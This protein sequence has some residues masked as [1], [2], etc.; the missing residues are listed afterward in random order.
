[1]HHWEVEKEFQLK[2]TVKAAIYF[3]SKAIIT[4]PPA[5]GSLKHITTSLQVL[6]GMRRK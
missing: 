3:E 6:D 1:M 2:E 4:K 5:R